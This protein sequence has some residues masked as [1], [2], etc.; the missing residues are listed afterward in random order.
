[1]ARDGLSTSA[2]VAQDKP[3]DKDQNFQFFNQLQLDTRL[4]LFHTIHDGGS[5]QTRK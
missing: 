5:K 1:M 3:I 2:T 4:R